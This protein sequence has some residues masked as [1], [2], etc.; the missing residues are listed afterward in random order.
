MFKSKVFKIIIILLVSLSFVAFLAE[1]FG[2]Y[3]SNNNI[4]LK[5]LFV[6]SAIIAPSVAYD[7]LKQM[8]S[9][10]VV[11]EDTHLFDDADA[12]V[13]DLL[14]ELRELQLT[15]SNDF[16][17]K[18]KSTQIE[19]INNVKCFFYRTPDNRDTS[20]TYNII[21]KMVDLTPRILIIGDSGSGKTTLIHHYIL[22]SLFLGRVN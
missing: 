10:V 12:D 14:D 17:H 4:I 20:T 6:I 9:R 21:E 13:S 8:K 5:I 18:V 1:Q 3:T 16:L 7:Y 15:E 2:L 22:C 19:Y 11:S